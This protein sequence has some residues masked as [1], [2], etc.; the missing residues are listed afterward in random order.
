MTTK[1]TTLSF[2]GG[3]QSTCILHMILRGEYKIETPLIV[4][5]SDPGMENS[6]TYPI[7][8]EM[9]EKCHS[10]GIEFIRV[11]RNLFEELMSL[12]SDIRNGVKTRFDNPPFFTKNRETGKRG[13][14]KQGCTQAYKIAP[15]DRAMRKWM[16]ENLKIGIKNKR[17][18]KNVVNKMIGFSNDEW[19]RIKEDDTGREY[20]FFSYPLIEMKMGEREIVKYYLDR[21]LK[22][23]SR[24]VCNACFSNDLD[25]FKEMCLN[26][27]IDFEQACLVDDEIRDLTLLGIKDECFVSSSLI[28]LRELKDLDFKLPNGESEDKEGR[29]HS[30]FCFF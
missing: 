16:E 29:C 2:S 13:R 28:S 24:S 11:R 6:K 25:T 18:G 21:N 23:P 22:I 15:M 27:P 12:K 20:S 1:L 7:I 8:D 30:G 19:M 4:L 3:K 9:E 17:I 10:A 5:N 26:R 14:L